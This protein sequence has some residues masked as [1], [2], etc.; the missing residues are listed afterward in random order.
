MA[1]KP[2]QKPKA[3][4]KGAAAKPRAAPKK[5]APKHKPVVRSSS[6]GTAKR[7]PAARLRPRVPSKSSK[8]S[9]HG[10]PRAVR[11]MQLVAARDYG[12]TLAAIH[13]GS[14][15]YAHHLPY[16]PKPPEP[17][18]KVRMFFVMASPNQ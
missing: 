9:R 14:E 3:K 12:I 11:S 13:A 17:G 16:Q 2:Q 10:K 8:P 18:H 5:L 7:K 15:A 1:K 4:P 6:A